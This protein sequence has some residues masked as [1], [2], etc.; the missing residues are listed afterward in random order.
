MITIFE[1]FEHQQEPQE[2]DYVILS[3]GLY[4]HIDNEL[5]DDDD[6]EKIENCVGQISYID[7]NDGYTKYNISLDSDEERV[8]DFDLW[9]D[10]EEIMEFSN[11]EDDIRSKIEAK[12]YN[13]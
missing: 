5:V 6:V 2:G 3:L 4:P 7:P 10:R 12:K 1:N 13:L 8:K 11:D 9:V